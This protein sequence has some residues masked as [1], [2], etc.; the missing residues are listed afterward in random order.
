VK[1]I[2]PGLA[3]PDWD[4]HIVGWA[5][6]HV[7]EIPDDNKKAVAWARGWLAMGAELV[8]DVAVKE[9]EPSE[10]SLA[11]LRAQAEAR[12]LPTYGSKA[13]LQERLAAAPTV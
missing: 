1:I 4:G 12:G 7:T 2:M 13:Q 8:E 6:G 5:P 11:D 3:G 9:P 10:P